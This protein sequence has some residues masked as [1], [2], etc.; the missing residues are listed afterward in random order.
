VKEKETYQFASKGSKMLKNSEV[1]LRNMHE[2][3]T[4]FPSNLWIRKGNYSWQKVGVLYFMILLT[5]TKI[6]D[7]PEFLKAGF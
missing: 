2:D 6:L 7:H 1:S 3:S 5:I 4:F